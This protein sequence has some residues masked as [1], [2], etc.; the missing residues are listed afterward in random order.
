MLLNQILKSKPP[1][2]IA[3][4]PEMLVSGVIAVLAEKRIGAVLVV[5][6]QGELIGILSER[7]VVRSLSSHAIGTLSLKASDLMTPNP[8]TATPATT[9]EQAMEM[10]TDGHFRHLP[11]VEGGRLIGLVSIGDVVKARIDQQAH[12]VDTLRTYV[13][14]RV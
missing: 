12:E 11:I 3:I 2:F 4:A 6:A 9:V 7:D 14:G 13:V 10:M 1:G 8:T 5:N